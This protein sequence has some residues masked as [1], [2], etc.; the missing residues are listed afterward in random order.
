MKILFVVSECIPFASTGGLGEVSYSLPRALNNLGIKVSIIMPLYQVV[1]NK[2]FKF[3]GEEII[4]LGWR[5]H[6]ARLF[7]YNYQGIN[8]YFIENQYYFQRE[9]LYSYDD[10]GERFAF[11]SLSIVKFLDKYFSFD[12]IHCHDH[13][14]ALVVAKMSKL[15]KRSKLV[16]TIHNITYQGIY[17]LNFYKD[18]LDFDETSLSLF[19]HNNKI[20]FMKAGIIASDITTTVSPRYARELKH[21]YFACGLSNIINQNY[22][23]IIGILNGIDYG[24]YNSKADL[25]ILYNYDFESINMK[26]KNKEHLKDLLKLPKENVPIICMISR[27]VDHKGIDLIIDK[28]RE[29]LSLNIHLIILGKGED[30][31][32][33]FF[34]KINSPNFRYLNQFNPIL[35]KKIYAGSDFLLMPSKYEPC[36]LSQM[37]ACR[38]G[39]IPI[40]R[41]TGGLADSIN[42]ENGYYF[43]RYDSLEMI[44]KIKEAINT[45]NNLKHYHKIKNGYETDFSWDNSAK[46]YLEVYRSLL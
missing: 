16:F 35:A 46:L 18:V 42:D 37:I 2:G 31:Y 14:S 5:K 36:G 17:D 25:D 1:Q 3:V 21:S 45:Y 30:K 13:H 44:N 41:R 9:N 8:Y 33:I 27:L 7:V 22:N 43:K 11:F 6:K 24:Y 19:M 40:V 34:E 23:K 29:L 26:I 20:N 10:D 4:K 12:I 38:Y 39:T 32:Q 15:S 28:I